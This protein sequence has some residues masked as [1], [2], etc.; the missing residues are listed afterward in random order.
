MTYDTEYYRL[1]V[2]RKIREDPD[3]MERR[4][5]DNTRRVA[6]RRGGEP[7]TRGGQRIPTERDIVLARSACPN[8][9]GSIWCD[10]HKAMRKL[11]DDNVD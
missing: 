11:R 5:R 8:C 9:V 2:I 7:R 4:R 1:W 10:V 3:Y 6:L